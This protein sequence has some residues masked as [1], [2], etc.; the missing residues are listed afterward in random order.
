MLKTRTLSALS[1]AVGAATVA[2]VLALAQP[3]GSTTSA[4]TTGSR[5][6]GR[7]YASL[8]SG[9]STPSAREI[10]ER[11]ASGV[12]AIRA[13]GTRTESS[14][15]ASPFGG[16]AEA[17]EQVDTG[18]GIVLSS[19]GLILTNDHVVDGA[20]KIAVSFDGKEAHTAR[21]TVI[22]SDASRD[23]A[24][25][26]VNPSGLHLHAL[27]L[28]GAGNVQIGD[29][30]YAIGNPFG[31]NWTLT[32]GVISATNRTIKAPDGSSIGGVLQTD[33]ALNPGNSG[34]P[35]IDA[36]GQ[37]IGV[38]SQIVSGSSSASGQGGSS[39]VGF[40]ISSDTIE[41]FL[42]EHNATV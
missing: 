28:V 22:A 11:D 10:Y 2:G 27:A 6:S 35:L 31:L 1:A 8:S 38:N 37:V 34:G 33:A 9:S 3:F 23:L 12:V 7:A 39:G 19:A 17:A 42:R 4:G 36:A 14:A 21:A 41:Q 26:Q 30:A 16:E 18:S 29:A 20:S 24:L 5:S 13:V 40:A 15:T 32:T 25:L